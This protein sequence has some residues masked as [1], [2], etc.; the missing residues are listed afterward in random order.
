MGVALLAGIAFLI[1]FARNAEVQRQ[2]SEVQQTLCSAWHEQLQRK[3]LEINQARL[4]LDAFTQV[5]ES[6]YEKA[7]RDSI[8]KLE[9]EILSLNQNLA[10][11]E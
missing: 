7:A 6:F 11:C 4:N 8:Q 3:Q 2:K 5:Q 1:A 9:Q 10:T